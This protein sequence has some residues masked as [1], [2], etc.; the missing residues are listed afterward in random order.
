MDVPGDRTQTYL[1]LTHLVSFCI[2]RFPWATSTSLCQR[3]SYVF[4]CELAKSVHHIYVYTW[5]KTYWGEITEFHYSNNKLC[6]YWQLSRFFSSIWCSHNGVDKCLHPNSTWTIGITRIW[7]VGLLTYWDLTYHRWKTLSILFALSL[8]TAF[9]FW[10]MVEN[11]VI[12]SYHWYYYR[13]GAKD[14]LW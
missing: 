10:C 4:I 13:I 6:L 5:F 8:T 1:Q 14:Y 2:V 7:L 12:I 11:S 9:I 3:A